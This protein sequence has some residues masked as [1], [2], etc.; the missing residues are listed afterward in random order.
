MRP[1]PLIL[2]S[3]ELVDEFWIGFL[4]TGGQPPES[5]ISSKE[6]K[7]LPLPV[8]HPGR[9]RDLFWYR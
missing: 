7:Y 3:Q 4:Q 9:P 8:D 5:I 1:E 6:A 2:I